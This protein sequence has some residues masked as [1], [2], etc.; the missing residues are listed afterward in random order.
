MP[1]CP[2]GIWRKPEKTAA[3]GVNVAGVLAGRLAKLP[4][5]SRLVTIP[6]AEKPMPAT[7]WATTA[8]GAAA[9]PAK[10]LFSPPPV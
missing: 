1:F 9:K 8:V 6:E 5:L 4:S 3:P 10:A 7:D 2:A